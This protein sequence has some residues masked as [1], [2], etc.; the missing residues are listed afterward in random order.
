MDE[1][2]STGPRLLTKEERR[3]RDAAR[4]EE[5]EQALREHAAA[6]EALYENRERLRSERLAREK[7]TRK[8]S[9]LAKIR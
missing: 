2:N 9:R 5:A 4:R 6:Q 8:P 7:A 3:L 1:Y